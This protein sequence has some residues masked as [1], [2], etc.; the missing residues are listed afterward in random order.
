MKIDE[1]TSDRLFEATIRLHEAT[2]TTTVR[3]AIYAENATHAKLLLTALYRRGS[4]LSFE[5]SESPLPKNASLPLNS[6]QLAKKSVADAK[7]RDDAE[8]DRKR[9]TKKIVTA[10]HKAV[11]DAAKR[12]R[13]CQ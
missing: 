4:V 10:Q 8:A 5:I 9:F 6:E 1:F 12:F 2:K 13:D 3:T 7:E 11:K